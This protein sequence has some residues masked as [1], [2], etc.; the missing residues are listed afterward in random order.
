MAE[1]KLWEGDFTIAF[2]SFEFVLCECITY[3]K[4]KHKF[5]ILEKERLPF[6]NLLGA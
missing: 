5:K 3:F 1:E 4:K 6:S 2:V